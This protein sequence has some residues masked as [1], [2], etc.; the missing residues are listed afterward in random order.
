MVLTERAA[1]IAAETAHGQN[2]R[3]RVKMVKRLF[4]DWI[5]SNRGQQAVVL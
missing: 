2:K 5:E 3:S 1:H 4:L